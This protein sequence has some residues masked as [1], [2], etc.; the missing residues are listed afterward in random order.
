MKFQANLI[1]EFTAGSIAE[2][3]K[4][5]N[6]LLELADDEHDMSAKAVELVTPPDDLSTAPPVILPRVTSHERT[7]GPHAD[8]L[9][10]AAGAPTPG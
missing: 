6:Q 4:R 2:A 8:S 10:A 7:P 9:S 3:G 1:F 5:V